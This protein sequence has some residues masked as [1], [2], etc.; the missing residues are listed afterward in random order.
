MIELI[1]IEIRPLVGRLVAGFIAA[2]AGVVSTKLQ[3]DI[4]Q[5]AW[6]GLTTFITFAVYAIA[7]RAS[8]VIALSKEKK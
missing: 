4:P 8:K 5:D 7:H 6:M 3:L 2:L 1:L